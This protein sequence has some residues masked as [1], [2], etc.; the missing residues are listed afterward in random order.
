MKLNTQDIINSVQF[1][2]D[3]C[4]KVDYEIAR[5]LAIER[6][7]VHIEAGNHSKRWDKDQYR[8]DTVGIAGELAF[9]KF[10]GL[11]PDLSLHV[12]GDDGIDFKFDF[13]GKELIVD[14]KAFEQRFAKAKHSFKLYVSER[15]M[16]RPTDIYV[17]ARVMFPNVWLLGWENKQ[18]M[19][20]CPK[21][22][23][24]RVNYELSQDKLKPMKLLLTGIKSAKS[25]V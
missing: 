19:S 23:L 10:S 16:S 3:T 17:L 2:D 8:A 25:L 24:N 5:K 21:V 18:S 11:E 13:K 7:N 1:V 9:S 15:E 20:Q 22:E 12:T 6:R 14:V 4:F